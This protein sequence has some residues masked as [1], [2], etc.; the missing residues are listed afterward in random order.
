MY[1]GAWVH[2]YGIMI[3]FGGALEKKATFTTVQYLYCTLLGVS[4][5]MLSMHMNIAY[6]S[7]HSVNTPSIVYCVLCTSEM[8]TDTLSTEYSE[9]YRSIRLVLVNGTVGTYR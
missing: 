4:Y 9:Y 6:R 3:V 7:P 2:W 5:S 8:L 1:I